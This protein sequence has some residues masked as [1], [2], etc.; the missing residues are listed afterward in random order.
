M[1]SLLQ[2]VRGPRGKDRLPTPTPGARAA[3]SSPAE[4]RFSFHF[5]GKMRGKR[6]SASHAIACE[7][8]GPVP[9]F[10]SGR[11]SWEDTVQTVAISSWPAL[12]WLRRSLV[13]TDHRLLLPGSPC[14]AA[15]CSPESVHK[16]HASMWFHFDPPMFASLL[17]PAFPRR[18]PGARGRLAGLSHLRAQPLPCRCCGAAVGDGAAGLGAF[19]LLSVLH[20][21]PPETQGAQPWEAR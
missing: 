9:L 10:R 13:N 12:W 21:V 2:P 19:L 3:G 14:E 18:S 7:Q 11:C 4:E 8:A 15:C 5:Q 16:S 20:K 17:W 1:S 6:P